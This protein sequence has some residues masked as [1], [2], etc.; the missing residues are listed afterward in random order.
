MPHI[1]AE[2]AASPVP[3]TALIFSFLTFI[4]LKSHAKNFLFVFERFF[5]LFLTVFEAFFTLFSLFFC[6]FVFLLLLLKSGAIL[7]PNTK[8]P[9][10]PPFLQ[11]DNIRSGSKKYK[12]LAPTSAAASPS[13]AQIRIFSRNVAKNAEISRKT[14]PSTPKNK[15]HT[16]AGKCAQYQL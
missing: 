15:T 12:N 2:L 14:A 13:A 3:I 16:S 10:F 7:I 5:A 4:C 6:V 8:S 11:I 9:H 1:K